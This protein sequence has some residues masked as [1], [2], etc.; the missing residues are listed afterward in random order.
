MATGQGEGKLWIET[1]WTPLRNWPWLAS[2][3]LPRFIYTS[4]FLLIFVI[5]SDWLQSIMSTY[6]YIYIYI[7]THECRSKGF[8]AYP[9]IKFVA[10]LSIFKGFTC[11]QNKTELWIRYS[12]FLKSRHV[13]PLEKY[14]VMALF[15][16]FSWELF[17]RPSHTHWHIYRHPDTDCFVVS[18]LF[19]VVCKAR[20]SKLG[21]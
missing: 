9:Y 5:L 15:S 18:Q 17:G 14:S 13:L 10:H 21:S 1:H 16:G 20:F 12:R 4:I 11:S 2:C 7:Y 8:D 3:L 19:G 6:I